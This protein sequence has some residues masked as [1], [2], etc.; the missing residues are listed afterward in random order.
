MCK[1]LTRNDPFDTLK[2]IYQ[3]TIQLLYYGQW[4]S[5]GYFLLENWQNAPLL[6]TIIILNGQVNINLTDYHRLRKKWKLF[7][8]IKEQQILTH[9]LQF[10]SFK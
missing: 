7:P 10:N 9:C 4:F 6:V 1:R 8:F 2:Y 3:I 5:V